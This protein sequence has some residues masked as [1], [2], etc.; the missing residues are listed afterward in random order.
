VIVSGDGAGSRWAIRSPTPGTVASC[1][2]VA[3]REK[4]AGLFILSVLTGYAWFI[5]TPLLWM[6][7]SSKGNGRA[8]G[9][10]VIFMMISIPVGAVG[11]IILGVRRLKRMRRYRAFCVGHP[12]P[13]YQI[14]LQDIMVSAVS[15]GL[16]MTV[17]VNVRHWFNEPALIALIVIYEVVTQFVMFFAVMDACRFSE[18][19]KSARPRALYVFGLMFLNA[20]VPFPILTALSW[21]VW[22]RGMFLAE[23]P[24][25]SHVIAIDYNGDETYSQ[26][27]QRVIEHKRPNA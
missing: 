7:I 5:G 23:T 24:S 22:R 15:L 17:I 18:R 10:L 25:L 6:L 14:W 2:R 3:Y 1:A 20:F 21:N 8:L 27:V 11:W 4:P 12:A 16:S 9:A 26:Y 19:L 13:K